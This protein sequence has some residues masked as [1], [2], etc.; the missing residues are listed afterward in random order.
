MQTISI[1]PINDNDINGIIH[2]IRERHYHEFYR[3]ADATSSSVEKKSHQWSNAKCL[4][5]YDVT[6]KETWNNWCSKN[7]PNSNCTISFYQHRLYITHYSIQSRTTSAADMPKSWTVTGSNDNVTWHFI[8]NQNSPSL[9]QS[10]V[11]H[12]FAVEYPGSYKYF[13]F[14][15]T[16]N[17]SNNRYFFCLSKIDFFGT[18]SPNFVTCQHHNYNILCNLFYSLSIANHN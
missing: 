7:E 9:L 12:N 18:A 8:D 4:L 11:T 3:F 6:A 14:T 10:A 16:S 2:W 1:S 5:N 15:Q 13:R 17:N